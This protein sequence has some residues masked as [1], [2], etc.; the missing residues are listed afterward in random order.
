MQPLD[1]L[2]I[3]LTDDLGRVDSLRTDSLGIART[4]TGADTLDLRAGMNLQVEVQWPGGPLRLKDRIVTDT[5]LESTT[6]VKEY[7]ITDCGGPSSDDHGPP[8]SIY[9]LQNSSEPRR[10]S[11]WYQAETPVNSLDDA[12]AIIV[13]VM[14]DNPTIILSVNGHCDAR[15]LDRENLA[16]A[17]AMQVIDLFV[18]EGIAPE[19]MKARSL[20]EHPIHLEREIAAMVDPDERERA[21]GRD[22]RVNYQV[23][24]YDYEP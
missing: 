9:F 8:P 16:M 11:A 13:K 4:H 5:L 7:Y 3:T 20:A 15:E 14:K 12:L 2:L 21:L 17:R 1:G 10:D 18:A 23:L 24:S 19:R 22:R 6:F